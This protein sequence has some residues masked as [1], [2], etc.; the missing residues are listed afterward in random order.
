[1]ASINVRRGKLV[2]DFRYLGK[3]FREQTI[4]PDTP[5]NRKQLNELALKM[6][7]EITLDIFDYAKY[8]AK[9]KR[10]EEV[11]ELRDRKVAATSRCP[12]FS[13]FA[14]VWYE[15]KKIEWKTT[16]QRKVTTTLNKYL[17]P[18][19]GGQVIKKI[20]KSDLLD[21]RASLANVQLENQKTLSASR[22]NQ[23]MI[24]LRMILQEAAERYGF[25]TPYKNI[26]NLKEVKPVVH[27]LSLTDVWR[28]INSV[29]MDFRNYYVVRFFTGMR[30]SEID[31]LKWK[32][33]DLENRLIRVVEALV[34]GKTETTKTASSV[35]N[36]HMSDRVFEAFE[37]QY[38]LSGRHSD[39][40][41]CDRKGKPLAYRN[42]NRRIWHPTLML[43]G[44]EPR[45]AYET[46]HTA[47]T[48]WLAAGENPEWIARQLGHSNTEMLFRVYSHYVP[49]LTRKD[50]SAFEALLQQSAKELEVTNEE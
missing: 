28:F 37:H 9:S 48:I 6:E 24:P 32:N 47:A 13:M 41:F 49:D 8:F 11:I 15:E 20:T 44:L 1:M 14:E 23:I 22:I 38:Q 5:F 34:D 3:R 40:V 2:I 12:L 21:F 50:G 26:R 42:V 36:I 43:L 7:A 45:R 4:L 17:N 39:Y 35:R 18:Y 16:Y 30:T 25:E 29:R 33:V 27:P 10:L 31:G 46:R 19:F